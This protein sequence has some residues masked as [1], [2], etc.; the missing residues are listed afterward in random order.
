MSIES[1]VGRG[2]E[3]EISLPLAL[4]EE[5]SDLTPERGSALLV[6]DDP[7]TRET[8]RLLLQRLGFEV[9]TSATA[10]DACALLNQTNFDLLLSDLDLG[11]DIDGLELIDIARKVSPMTQSILMS[12]KFSRKHALPQHATFLQKPITQANLAG[13]LKS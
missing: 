9:Q 8:V 6:E 7:R 2:T 12:G 1:T 3:I 11:C 13:A 4:A 5:I 10:P